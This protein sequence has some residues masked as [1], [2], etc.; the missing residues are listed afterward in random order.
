MTKPFWTLIV[1]LVTAAAL[2]WACGLLWFASTIPTAVD[3]TTTHT[4]AIV[5]L[6]GGS[7]RI[8]TGLALLEDGLATH[9]F[10]S[11]VGGQV[12]TGDLLPRSHNLRPELLDDITVGTA[13]GNTPGNAIE[14]AVWARASS[15]RSSWNLPSTRSLQSAN[16]RRRS[17]NSSAP[18]AAMAAARVAPT[19]R[20]SIWVWRRR[21]RRR[22]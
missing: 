13:A 18:A 1:G 10:V 19:S 8:E 14:T 22:R 9:L 6:T 21:R 20:Q 11:G 5:V 3:D 15:A 2:G 7:E 12:K 16:S 17:A 4:D